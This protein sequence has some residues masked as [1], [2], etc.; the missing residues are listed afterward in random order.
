[1]SCPK[2]FEIQKHRSGIEGSGV[3]MDY[4]SMK[5]RISTA[6]KA[7]VDCSNHNDSGKS[8][9]LSQE[10]AD[11]LVAKD[12]NELSMAERERVLHDIHG[13]SD[14]PEEDVS[15]VT[16]KFAALDRAIQKNITKGSAYE[17]A[18]STS[19][20]YVKDYSSRLKFLRA[21][22]F[23]AEKAAKRMLAFF[24]QKLRIFG[25]DKLTKDITLQDLNEE[26]LKVLNNGHLQLL[27]QRDRAGRLI[28]CNVRSYER[29]KDTINLVGIAWSG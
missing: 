29:F 19:E 20:G 4:F 5:E 10:E 22:C 2:G 24:E 26:D 27:P 15:K 9:K 23:D 25:R 3:V 21:D 13:V 8:L 14:I 17:Q 6:L 12:M 1:M 11:A 18:L 7:T 28:C 16:A